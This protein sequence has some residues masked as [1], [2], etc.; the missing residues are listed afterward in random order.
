MD[1]EVKK[2]LFDI[3][4]SIERIELFIGT[5]MVYSNFENNLLLIQAVERNFE[6]M[7]E[8]MSRIIKKN[9]NI[10]ISHKRRIV[11]T[12]NKIIHGYDEI[13]P[14]NLWNII[15][16]NLPLLKKEATILLNA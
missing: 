4:S 5:P 13:E 15:I 9:P 1:D 12:R 11:D 3:L 14:Q 7:G 16:V 8:A 2:W 6:I 10:E